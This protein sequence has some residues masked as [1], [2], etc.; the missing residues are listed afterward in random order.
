MG[1]YMFGLLLDMRFA[2]GYHSL[3]SWMNLVEVGA[4]ALLMQVIR[5]AHGHCSRCSR[6][7]FALLIHVIHFAHAHRSLCSRTIFALLTNVV[8]AFVSLNLSLEKKGITSLSVGEPVV[9]DVQWIKS[10]SSLRSDG[11]FLFFTSL[12]RE[13]MDS[14]KNKKA[15]VLTNK[16]FWSECPRLDSNQHT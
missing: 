11:T 3:C 4:F 14:M 5:F 9:G 6:A 10:T 1:N 13:R 2:Y 16:C 15:P 7:L 8:G 12:I